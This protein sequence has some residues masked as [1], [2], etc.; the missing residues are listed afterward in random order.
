MGT[1]DR[2]L[3]IS[4]P[5][6]W[7]KRASNPSLERQVLTVY[8]LTEPLLN[9]IASSHHVRF[10]GSIIWQSLVHICQNRSID[11]TRA[12]LENN[13]T[14]NMCSSLLLTRLNSCFTC[15]K[16]FWHLQGHITP[17]HQFYTWISEQ[18][19]KKT[20]LL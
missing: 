16:H 6:M 7:N 18:H 2:E 15:S 14:S 13:I 20:W 11:N 1:L 3:N 10:W 9:I 12:F 5:I 17:P 8:N 19:P 4:N